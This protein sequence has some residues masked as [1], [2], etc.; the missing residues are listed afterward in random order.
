MTK[1]ILKLSATFLGLDQTAE[2]L[3]SDK[4]QEPSDEVKQQINQLI[5]FMNYVIREIT[6][7][8]FPLVQKETIT[9]DQDG[10][11]HFSKLKRKAT[12]I[13]DVK[14]FLDLS[15]HFEIFPEFLKVENPNTEYKVFYAFSPKNV[16]TLDDEIELPFGID[17]F[18]IC[19]GIASEYALVNGLNDEAEM[20]ESKFKAE[21]KSIKS[22]TGERR[23]FARRLK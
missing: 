21:L 5:I 11:I 2:Y 18:V 13:K 20:W 9:S 17:Y 16:Q 8:F 14:N 1:E 6:K 23:F 22:R 19:F 7:D 12:Q 3:S 15:C 10:K 4:S